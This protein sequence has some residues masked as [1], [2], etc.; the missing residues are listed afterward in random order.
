M[1]LPLLYRCFIIALSLLVG[2]HEGH[3]VCRVTKTECRYVDDDDLCGML[4]V[5]EF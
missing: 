5:I 3:P 2:R 1:V 4:Q